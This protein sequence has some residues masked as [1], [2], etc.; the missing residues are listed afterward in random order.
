MNKTID[1][2]YENQKISDYENS[3]S[4]RFDFLIEDLNLNQY[5]NKL[6]G[7]FG[8][9]YG[10]IFDR[11]LKKNNTFIGFDGANLNDLPFE[12]FCVDLSYDVFSEIYF[13]K[14]SERL[15]VGFCFETLEHLTNPY[16][17]LSEIKKIIKYDGITYLS[18]PNI[19]VLHN[20]IYPSLLYPVSGFI[21]FLN[22]MAFEIIDHR[23]HNKSFIQEVFIL[24]NKD[25]SFSKMKFPNSKHAFNKMTPIEY[26]NL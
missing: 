24:K 21:E 11:I 10:P 5:E 7:D 16:H 1:N 14:Y 23:I 4:A 15:D 25:W 6:I 9:G 3:H 13:K 19:N 22:Q 26:A 12:Y 20:T 17:A 8:C 18:I 2:F